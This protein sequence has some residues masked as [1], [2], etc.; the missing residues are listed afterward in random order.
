MFYV[1]KLEWQGEEDTG[2]V[3]QVLARALRDYPHQVVGT[4]AEFARLFPEEGPG[5]L[6]SCS[7]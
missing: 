4:A 7:L 3:D 1:I 6:S 2:R 5:D